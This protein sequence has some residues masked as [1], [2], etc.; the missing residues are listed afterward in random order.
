MFSSHNE[1]D[2]EEIVSNLLLSWLLWWELWHFAGGDD[3]TRDIRHRKTLWQSSTQRSER[4]TTRETLDRF[5]CARGFFARL[6]AENLTLRLSVTRPKFM[7]SS[8][9]RSILWASRSTSD[10]AMNVQW[11]LILAVIKRHY[12]NCRV[13]AARKSHQ[14]ERA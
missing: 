2:T 12:T 7:P 5:E 4:S 11:N 8:H 3:V 13:S 1:N 10:I 14:L 6:I 9:E